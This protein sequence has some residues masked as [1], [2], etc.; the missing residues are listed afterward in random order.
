MILVK[1]QYGYK[2]RTI[3]DR[4]NK[5]HNHLRCTIEEGV[6]TRFK[7]RYHSH[8]SM[9]HSLGQIKGGHAP[10]MYGDAHWL[11]WVGCEKMQKTYNGLS[12]K[13]ITRRC[14]PKS[15]LGVC[16]CANVECIF[17]L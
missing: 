5:I 17:R 6:Q 7:Y 1:T 10:L 2:I 12:N 13:P 8:V 9:Q 11:K 3:F 14:I 16:G 4:Y 15:N